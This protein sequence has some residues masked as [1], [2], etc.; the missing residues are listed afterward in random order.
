MKNHT[1]TYVA[2]M[3]LLLATTTTLATPTTPPTLNHQDTITL[4]TPYTTTIDGQTVITIPDVQQTT[5]IP[6]EPLL[7]VQRHTYE[8]PLGTTIT[9]ITVTPQATTTQPLTAPVTMTPRPYLDNLPTN[10]VPSPVFTQNQLYPS[11]WYTSQLTSGLNQYDQPTA[12]LT[13]EIHPVRI[14][15]IQQTMQYTTSFSVDI[16]YT[17]PSNPQ[18]LANETKLVI[19]TTDSY[20]SALVPLMNHKIAHGFSTK[21]VTINDIKKETFFPAQGRDTAEKMKYFIKAAH[22]QWGTLY[23]M[24]VGNFKQVPTR[25][26]WIE[27]DVGAEYQELNFAS[28]LYFA[29]LYNGTG[30]FCSWDTNNNGKYG[31]WP[32]PDGSLPTDKMD[33]VP[34]V[35]LARLA[36]MTKAEVRTQVHKIINYETTTKNASWFTR[37]IVA[38]GDTFDKSYEGGTDYNE[39]EVATQA[40]LDVMNGFTPITLFA[41][42]GT[43]SVEN[44]TAEI[45]QGAGFLYMCG[46]GNPKNWATHFH[47]SKNWTCNYNNKVVKTLSNTNKCPVLMVGG[48]HNSEI[49]VTPMNMVTGILREGMKYFQVGP[50][51]LGEYFL[52]DY[53]PECWSWVFVRSSGGAI[54]SMGSCGFG[55]DGVGDYNH[56]GVPDCVEQ[57]DGWFEVN[58]FRLFNQDHVTVLGQ[59]YDQDVTMYCQNFPIF[60]SRYDAKDMATHIILGDPTLQIGG[61]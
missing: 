58:F 12:F 5:G 19:L 46:H 24:L 11:T 56:N 41:S 48:C 21:I 17:L 33:L 51:W 38:G 59:T 40:A 39:G 36:C 49:D 57:Y 22:E 15:P 10:T 52:Y 53:V 61:Y 7:P 1:F 47:D 42:T 54:A 2:I 28:D 18:A 60:S 16:R 43:L 44:V 35:H 29:D 26:V 20:K 9:T 4:A 25:D 37:M 50:N 6:G 34:D 23:V 13:L 45:N 32:W 27:T 8:F 55:C 14:N 31:E 3:L 30:G